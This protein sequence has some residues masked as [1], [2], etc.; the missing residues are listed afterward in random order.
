MF[1]RGLL[2][3]DDDY[4]TYGTGS[5][6]GTGPSTRKSWGKLKLPGPAPNS[7]HIHNFLGFHRETVFPKASP[8]GISVECKSATD[9]EGVSRFVVE[10]VLKLA[11]WQRIMSKLALKRLTGSD[12]TLFEWQFGG[13]GQ[14]SIT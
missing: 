14:K 8:R 7:G 5:R 4:H 2:S 6:S 13:S 9:G 11:I 10:V 3:L 1:D 12:L